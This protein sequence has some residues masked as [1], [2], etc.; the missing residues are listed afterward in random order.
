MAHELSGTTAIYK[1]VGG[2]TAPSRPMNVVATVS[3]FNAKVSWTEPE[4]DGGKPV[5]SYLVKA[6]P[7]PDF[8]TTTTTSCVI[9]GLQKASSIDSQLLRAT[10]IPQALRQLLLTTFKPSCLGRM[11]VVPLLSQRNQPQVLL[12]K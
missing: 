9:K 3:T 2:V 11:Q 6:I 10:A 1:V 4:D 8:C 5:A 12:R 7:G